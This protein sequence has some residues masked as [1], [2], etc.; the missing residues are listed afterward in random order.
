MSVPLQDYIYCHKDKMRGN[1][2]RPV[3]PVELPVGN[4]RNGGS[5]IPMPWTV[6]IEGGQT[7]LQSKRWY[8][9]TAHNPRSYGSGKAI[10]LGQLTSDPTRIC[11]RKTA[12]SPVDVVIDAATGEGTSFSRCVPFAS[13][14]FRRGVKWQQGPLKGRRVMTGTSNLKPQRATKETKASRYRLFQ[15][16]A[17][18]QKCAGR[19]GN[20]PWPEALNNSFAPRSRSSLNNTV[21]A[22]GKRRGTSVP[23]ATQDVATQITEAP[24]A[25]VGRR[26]TIASAICDLLDEGVLFDL[27]QLLEAAQAVNR[28]NRRP[29]G[30]HSRDKCLLCHAP[31]RRDSCTQTAVDNLQGGR[32]SFE[33]FH[34]FETKDTASSLFTLTRTLSWSSLQGTL[35][36]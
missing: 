4:S 25:L 16:T 20:K 36:A 24:Q 27:L 26:G 9:A 8:P 35:G 1:H 13:F 11:K 32:D 28:T 10:E 17:T 22:E 31:L 19:N 33:R 5:T 23:R 34:S 3:L 30:E 21:E 18:S 14:I 29:P 12:A 15:R 2:G 7:D 6:L